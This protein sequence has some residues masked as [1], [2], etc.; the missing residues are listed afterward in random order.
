MTGEIKVTGFKD[1]QKRLASVGSITG[2]RAMRGAMFA[3]TKPLL[4]RTKQNAGIFSH[5]GAL[6]QSLR[7]LF[8]VENST[9]TSGDGSRFTISVGPKIR[10][11]LAITLYNLFYRRKRPRRG[12]YHGHF[13]EW[14]T[15]TGTQAWHFMAGAVRSMASSTTE[16]LAVQLGKR[17]D[18]ATKTGR[19]VND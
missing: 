10:D 18:K 17:L 3:S 15:K 13:L 8:K 12:I 7:R 2:T 4:E 9:L 11:R 1:L 19:P 14:G 16:L 5:S 6:R